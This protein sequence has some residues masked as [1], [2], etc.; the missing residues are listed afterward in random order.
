[1]CQAARKS[2]LHQVEV[3][4]S[5]FSGE[6][7]EALQARIPALVCYILVQFSSWCDSM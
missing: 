5:I 1:M 6:A 7:I 3:L 4:Q 2:I